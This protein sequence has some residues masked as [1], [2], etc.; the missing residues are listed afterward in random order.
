MPCTIAHG[1][2]DH[3]PLFIIG[4]SF[5]ME[6]GMSMTVRLSVLSSFLIC[7]VGF[8]QGSPTPSVPTYDEAKVIVETYCLGCHSGDTA[9]GE[10]V[11]ETE[12]DLRKFGAQ[13]LEA[14]KSG[15]MPAGEPE[16]GATDEGKLLIE[17]LEGAEPLPP[18]Y[19]QVKP[20]FDANCVSCHGP[21]AARGGIRLDTEAFA[22]RNA[23]AAFAILNRGRMPP[24]QPTFKD[25]TAGVTMLG[26]LKAQIP[27]T[28]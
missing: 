24:R 25:S 26:W 23:S 18:T 11:L 16:F 9:S 6:I 17:Y 19:G 12:D 21:R 27:S 28:P 22:V 20:L 4:R 3:R 14:I 5:K 2:T 7:S 1:L 10:V 13:A 15:T 8:A